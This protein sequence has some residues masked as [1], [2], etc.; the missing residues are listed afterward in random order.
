MLELFQFPWSPYCLVQRHI[1]EYA[2]VSFKIHNIP[3]PDRTLI[4]KITK[5]R[6]YQVPV[7]R[8]GKTVVF[9][10][11]NDSQV[12]G[13]YLDQKLQLGLFPRE[14]EG[15]Q[16][17]LWRYIENEI[18]D[19]TFRLNDVYY[20]EMVPVAQRLG[21]IRH[22]E[23]KFGRGCLEIW[24]AQQKEMLA[25]LEKRLLPCEQMLAEKP[26]LL[27]DHAL[28]VDF[29]LLG[30]LENF[31][32]SGHYQ[33]PSAYVRLKEWHNRIKEL[34]VPSAQREKLH[35]RHQRPAS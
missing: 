5:Q 2:R 6:Y 17:I 32:Y 23:R 35:S 14:W 27:S 21:F 18:E 20:Q 34:K 29:D 8:D 1:L 12:V 30:M 3:N 24:A 10:T 31:L 4:W 16:S 13:K 26:F 11:G 15:V 28:F 9:E 19:L 7:V 33:L 22:K 25:E